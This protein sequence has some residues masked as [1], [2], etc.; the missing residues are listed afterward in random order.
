MDCETCRGS[1]F[2]GW[3]WWLPCEDCGGSGSGNEASPPED[4]DELARWEGE[5]GR[6]ES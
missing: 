4:L 5:G 3:R 2:D 6:C 1:G